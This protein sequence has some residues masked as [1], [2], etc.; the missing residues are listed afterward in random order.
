MNIIKYPVLVLISVACL[1]AGCRPRS[2]L[3]SEKMEDILVDLHKADGIILVT[4]MQYN[5]DTL[6]QVCYGE[7]LEK[8]KITQSQFDSS[9]V[10]YTAHPQLFNKIYPHVMARLEAEQNQLKAEEVAAKEAKNIPLQ[11]ANQ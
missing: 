1:L 3:S 4:G 11:K 10:W 6:Q 9:L 5:R 7:V 8:H 2:V